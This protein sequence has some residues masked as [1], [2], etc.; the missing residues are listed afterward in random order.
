MNLL[1][2]YIFYNWCFKINVQWNLTFET[3]HP[4]G[5]AILCGYFMEIASSPCCH[6]YTKILFNVTVWNYQEFKG[7][8]NNR[9]FIKIIFLLCSSYYFLIIQFW[10]VLNFFVG[11]LHYWDS[12][13]IDF[14]I[15]R[16][17]NSLVTD[18][19]IDKVGVNQ[20]FSRWNWFQ[21]N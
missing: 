13:Y 3:A 1:V 12:S 18:R 15:C 8:S 16:M 5:A 20:R 4:P 6:S 10:T 7:Y 9:I 11:F 2:L 21:G 19:Y 17:I 14:Y